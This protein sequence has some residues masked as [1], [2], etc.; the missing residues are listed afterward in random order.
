MQWLKD[1]WY[2]VQHPYNPFGNLTPEEV[3]YYIDTGVLKPSLF[4]KICNMW[5]NTFGFVIDFFPLIIVMVILF[6]LWRLGFIDT[7]RQIVKK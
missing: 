1:F 2:G 4:Q 6:I 7:A 5:D 3:Q